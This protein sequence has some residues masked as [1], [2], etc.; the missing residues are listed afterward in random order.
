MA[1]GAAAPGSGAE[2]ASAHSDRAALGCR[3]GEGRFELEA[4]QI[5]R[6]PPQPQI[7]G[8]PPP[9]L[10]ARESR[11]KGNGVACCGPPSW[12]REPGRADK[13]AVLTVPSRSKD[14]HGS[15][16]GGRRSRG[17][18]QASRNGG[19][20]Q[21]PGCGQRH[22][23]SDIGAA[24]SLVSFAPCSAAPSFR[25]SAGVG[26]TVASAHCSPHER[27]DL[28]LFGGSQLL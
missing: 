5:A 11:H 26:R 2:W 18:P 23:H 10:S 21:T 28:R 7:R 17:E 24:E 1:S 16:R 3:E 14:W 6:K 22:L 19:L 9:A 20:G 8:V 12:F 25:P 4:A 15:I 27:S 13:A